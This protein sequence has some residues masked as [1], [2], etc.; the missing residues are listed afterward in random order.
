MPSEVK[1]KRFLALPIFASIFLLAFALIACRLPDQG[2]FPQPPGSEI[3][4]NNDAALQFKQKFNNAMEQAAAGQE[5][6]L[7]V[8]NEEA[9]SLAAV[10]LQEYAQLPI[11][12][13]QVWFTSGKVYM[14]GEINVFGPLTSKAF[15]VLEALEAD[16]KVE[17]SIVE[18]KMGSL[19]FPQN[20]LDRIS[21][22]LNE[23]VDEMQ[24]D[25]NVQRLDILE[26]EMQVSGTRKTP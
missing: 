20:V 4:I 24:T 15:I 6:H 1:V 12:S 26:G 9:T 2:N 22:T 8:T 19:P 17:I 5:F 21:R 10:N 25:I 16:N 11:A 13:P 3:K 23:T 18:A 7:K 14:T